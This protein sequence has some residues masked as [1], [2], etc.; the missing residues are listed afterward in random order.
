MKFLYKRLELGSAVSTI[1]FYSNNPLR[2]QQK[3][4]FT[5]R[6]CCAQKTQPRCD[7]GTFLRA[8]IEFTYTMS[9]MY[10]PSVKELLAS[11]NKSLTSD[12]IIKIIV[13]GPSGVGKSCLIY[14]FTEGQFLAQVCL[15]VIVSCV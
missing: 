3:F 7:T 14:T 1:S 2:L 10:S 9:H 11:P 8:C 13:I 5:V 15:F 12:A 6:T 4:P